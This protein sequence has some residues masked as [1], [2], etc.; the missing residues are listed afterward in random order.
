M[1]P[2]T[3]VVMVEPCSS[4]EHTVLLQTELALD[5]PYVVITASN[6][7]IR[8]YKKLPTFQDGTT[9][10]I[11]T[12]HV[13]ISRSG[14]Q[15]CAQ[16]SLVSGRCA[17]THLTKQWVSITCCSVNCPGVGDTPSQTTLALSRLS[18]KDHCYEALHSADIPYKFIKCNYLSQ[19]RARSVGN[20]TC[21]MLVT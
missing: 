13:V 18:S 8:L 20:G 6:I 7:R 19:P 10:D 16:R 5:C 2:I 15:A 3:A 17:S 12:M 14:E 9:C 1:A 21:V 11:E 4:R